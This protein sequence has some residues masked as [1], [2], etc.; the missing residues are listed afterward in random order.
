MPLT[1]VTHLMFTIL[2]AVPGNNMVEQVKNLAPELPYMAAFF[3]AHFSRCLPN[4]WKL[5]I[6]K[7]LMGLTDLP[8]IYSGKRKFKSPGEKTQKYIVTLFGLVDTYTLLI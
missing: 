5:Y 2:Q 3:L 6:R 7:K 8:N 1:K 4:I